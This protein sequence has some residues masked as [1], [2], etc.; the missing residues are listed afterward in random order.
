[1]TRFAPVRGLKKL[2]VISWLPTSIKL[3]RTLKPK[4]LVYKRLFAHPRPCFSLRLLFLF[5]GMA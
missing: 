1:M 3:I 4:G 5:L 2:R